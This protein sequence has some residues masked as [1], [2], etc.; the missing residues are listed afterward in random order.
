MKDNCSSLKR[1]KRKKLQKTVKN[2]AF[3]VQIKAKLKDPRLKDNG[4]SV[5]LKLKCSKLIDTISS[6]TDSMMSTT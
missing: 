5:V 6:V 1:E 3:R 4:S 2:F